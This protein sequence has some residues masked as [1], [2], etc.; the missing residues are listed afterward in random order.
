MNRYIFDLVSHVLNREV[1]DVTGL[2]VGIVDDVEL[3]GGPEGGVL[4][5]ALIVGPGPGPGSARSRLPSPLVSLAHRVFGSGR[6]RVPWN[7]I[8]KL[9]ERI[10]LA[11]TAAALGLGGTDRRLGRLIG[12]APGSWRAD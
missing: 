5:K 10:E 9:S 6:T 11:A 4:V 12:K 2:P 3:E 7:Q 1:V 8:G